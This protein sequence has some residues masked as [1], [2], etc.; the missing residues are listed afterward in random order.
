MS[1]G[2]T[3]VGVFFAACNLTLDAKGEQL[4]GSVGAIKAVAGGHTTGGN[5]MPSKADIAPA[6][7]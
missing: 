5:R 1:G 7:G 6:W 2:A 3:L 4:P